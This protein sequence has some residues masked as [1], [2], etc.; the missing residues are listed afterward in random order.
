MASGREVVENAARS[1]FD[2][3]VMPSQMP[4]MPAGAIIGAI[5]RSPGW[6]SRIP[7]M[8]IYPDAAGPSQRLA[9]AV[10]AD[11][12]FNKPL[13]LSRFLAVVKCHAE[14]GRQLRQESAGWTMLEYPICGIEDLRSPAMGASFD[15][16]QLRP[17]LGRG[18]FSHAMLGNGVFSFGSFRSAG[19]LRLRGE[20]AANAVYLATGLGS[21]RPDSFWGRDLAFGDMGAIIATETGQEFDSVHSPGQI[22]Y[23]AIAVPKEFFYDFVQRV[24]PD[25]KQ[26]ERPIVHQPSLERRF[27]TT[28]A[29]YSAI[30]AIR[31]AS[32]GGAHEFDPRQLTLSILNTF[33]VALGAEEKR[34]PPMSR[35]REIIARVEELV[36]SNKLDGS[37]PGICLQLGEAGRTIETAF[38]RELNT[39][40]AH[41]LKVFQLCRAREDLTHGD[42]SVAAIAAKHGFRRIG[43]F[44]GRYKYIFGEFPSE[45]L[46]FG[47]GTRVAGGG[48][49]STQPTVDLLRRV[50]R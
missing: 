27:R 20:F 42:E 8:L 2:L 1:D 29:I 23:A 11:A 5:R 49:G 15:A 47:K 7:I 48:H 22:S 19:T 28:R 32:Q 24:A 31:N 13:P 38:R 44:V 39:S 9:E 45:T 12:Y 21:D 26:L 16:T 3:I 30:K 40:P 35:D 25:F 46:A 41:Y 10:S 6:I 33:I 43:Q 18:Y 4:D 17:G 36:R 50:L 34:V 14:A 37:V